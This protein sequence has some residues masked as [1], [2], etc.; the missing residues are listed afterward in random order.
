EGLMLGVFGSGMQIALVLSTYQSLINRVA[1]KVQG[2][3]V[4]L[5]PYN[6]F[7]FK[8]SIVLILIGVV[9]GVWGSLTSIRKYLRV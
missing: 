9:I 1:P 7:V 5:L 3:F 2:S 6:P 4:S 8:V